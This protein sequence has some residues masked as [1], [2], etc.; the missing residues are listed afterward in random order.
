MTDTAPDL[1][2]TLI[3]E[4][5]GALKDQTLTPEEGTALFRG[6]AEALRAVVDL[7]PTFWAKAIIRVAAQICDEAA[8]GIER[9]AN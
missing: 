6:L 1:V 8:E 7:L 2:F 9:G 4:V 3:R 5:I